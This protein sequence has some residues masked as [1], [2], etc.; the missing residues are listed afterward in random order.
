MQLNKRNSFRIGSIHKL[1][2]CWSTQPNPVTERCIEPESTD[3]A[4]EVFQGG[5]QG[6]QVAATRQ[7]GRA[8]TECCKFCIPI[9]TLLQQS[10]LQFPK[11]LLFTMQKSL[12]DLQDLV[13]QITNPSS[14][15]E[16]SLLRTLSTLNKDAG[17]H[18]LSV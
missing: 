4:A 11:A 18:L 2:T 8:E 7:I 10:D 3:R 17:V 6:F 12:K 13:Y 16:F 15:T 9:N 1:R 14:H 5:K